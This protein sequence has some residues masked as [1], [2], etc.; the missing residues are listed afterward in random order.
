MV[1]SGDVDGVDILAGEQLAE[2]HIGFAVLV[3]MFPVNLVFALVADVAAHVAN[4]HVL[5]ER[6]VEE[7][8]HVAAAHV[9][10]A[11]APHDDA[12]ARS[13]RLSIAEGTGR[14]DGGKSEGGGC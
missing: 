5:D 14:D 12:V 10:E 7:V 8:A 13:W 1:R 11:D 3:A 6:V 9:A 2:I 4:G